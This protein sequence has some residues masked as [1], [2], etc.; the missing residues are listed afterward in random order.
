MFR[1]VVLTGI[2]L[3]L[4][5][6]VA[7]QTM[8][9]HAAAAT[10]GTTGAVA[11]KKVSD[12]L[13]NIFQKVGKQAATAAKTDKQDPLVVVGPAEV[14]N[15]KKPAASAD[16]AA[17]RA[18]PTRGAWVAPR[19]P[20]APAESPVVL[21]PVPPAPTPQAP[22]PPPEPPAVSRDMLA[23]VQPGEDGTAVRARLGA[24]SSA[25]SM[26]DDGHFIEVLRYMSK[27]TTV[28]TVRLSDGK[29]SSV[30]VAQP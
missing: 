15:K 10:G 4:S 2:A 28:G 16:A 8:V 17:R 27:D 21:P 30:T 1:L 12:G 20:V 26:F 7:A 9:E 24:P 5:G 22:A 23:A 13:T 3:A 25:I 18:V 6:L 11:G 14:V 29:V 19:L